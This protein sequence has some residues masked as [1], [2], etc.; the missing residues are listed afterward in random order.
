MFTAL[1]RMTPVAGALL[2]QRLISAAVGA[3]ALAAGLG[4]VAVGA[5][6]L[7]ASAVAVT[8]GF[9][10]LARVAGVPR[11]WFPRAERSELRRHAAPFAAQ[12]VLAVG[13][14]RVD[15]LLLS[16]LAS[17]AVVGLYG[18]AYRLFEATLLVS[19]ALVP[20]FAA[21]FA[22]LAPDAARAAFARSLKLMLVLL[23]PCAVVL[24]ILPGPL[25]RL[26]FGDGFGAAV[27]ALRVLAPTAVVLGVVLITLSLVVSRG[28]P[29]ASVRAFAL[30]LGAN[31]VLNLSLI[32]PLG[33]TG[34][35]LAMLG[36][37]SVLAVA[38]LRRAHRLVGGLPVV[39]ILG[40]P[41]TAAMAMAPVMLPLA[42]TPVAALILGGAV[43]LAVVAAVELR[44]WPDDAG[45]VRDLLR[46]RVAQAR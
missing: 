28:D 22:Y 33:A 11:W 37:E 26:A 15:A 2:C 23:A 34:A 31:V 3:V 5:A 36:T 16:V 25:L 20:A 27:G 14:T 46:R 10:F 18:A 8:L 21:M 35:A 29:R 6:Y 13:I 9:A 19:S 17:S 38:L 30:A 41:L 4:V 40:G 1:E 44:L 43:Y 39:Q 7:L 42:G 24:A 45:T 12:E 32:P